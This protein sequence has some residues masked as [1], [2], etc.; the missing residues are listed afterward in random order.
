MDLIDYLESLRKIDIEKA[1]IFAIETNSKE[2]ADDNRE[3]LNEGIRSDNETV[4]WL[5]DN[6]Y[7]YVKPYARKRQKAGLQ[8]EI[9]DLNFN[10]DFVSS[11]DAKIQGDDILWD[12][13]TDIAKYQEMNY[14]KKIYGVT[15]ENLNQTIE[16]GIEPAFI[17]E[18]GRQSG[19]L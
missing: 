2:L 16:T 7:P 8:T 3:Q 13:H 11:I 1:A 18:V 17:A 6:H 10:G 5:K 19:L 12:G 9:V 4:H 14:S 15:D